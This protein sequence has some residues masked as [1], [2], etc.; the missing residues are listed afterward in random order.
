MKKARSFLFKAL[1]E[2]VEKNLLANKGK[3]LAFAGIK[4]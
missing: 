3:N 4:C 2:A 1:F